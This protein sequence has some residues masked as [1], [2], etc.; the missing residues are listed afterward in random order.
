[1]VIS[2]YSN[3]RLKKQ[4]GVFL[5]ASSFTV[6]I[7]DVIEKGIITK[8]SRN[9]RSEFDNNYFYVQGENKDHSIKELD[10]LGINEATLFPELEHQLSYIKFIH[11]DQTQSVSD[12]HQYEENYKKI[13]SY[14]NVNE[15]ILNKEFTSEV[16]K[17]L[18]DNLDLKDSEN[19]LKI[20][21][22]NL[23]VDW[24][25]RENIRS[26]IKRSISTYCLSNINSLDVKESENLVNQIMVI[27]N[28]LIKEHMFNEQGGE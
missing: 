14:E 12:F 15:E 7:N 27:M 19:I 23:V 9:L 24:Y 17:I 22:D 6:E 4:S 20:I 13:I 16:E 25:Q 10:L 5:L 18:S 1:M 8:S 2:T 26:K 28:R 21:K 3:E 11:Q